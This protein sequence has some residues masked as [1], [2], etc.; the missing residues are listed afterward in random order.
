MTHFEVRVE[1]ARQFPVHA[2]RAVWGA[3]ASRV[4][5]WA[6]RPNPSFPPLSVGPGNIMNNEVFGGTPKRARETRA[7]PGHFA[8]LDANLGVRIHRLG[9]EGPPAALVSQRVVPVIRSR[10]SCPRLRERAGVREGTPGVFWR[11]HVP[12]LRTASPSPQ[13]SPSEGEGGGQ[14]S[15]PGQAGG[16][17]SSRGKAPPPAGG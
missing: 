5:V 10:R 14:S 7:L 16:Q 9:A 1:M 15:C 3:H 2:Q 6:S 17:P 12:R 13:P 11:A 4:Q 8:A